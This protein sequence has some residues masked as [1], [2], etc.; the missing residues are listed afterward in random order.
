VQGYA[1]N[2]WP[3]VVDVDTSRGA[4]A[5]IE[6]RGRDTGPPIGIPLTGA[7]RRTQVVYLPYD[8]PFSSASVAKF[9]VRSTSVG[10]DGRR[11][12]APLGMFG[13]GAGPRAVGSMTIEVTDFDPA[14]ASRPDQ[15]RYAV[16][17]H[18]LFDRSAIEILRMPTT[19]D[20]LELIKDARQFP[21]PP[22]LHA[23]DWRTMGVKPSPAAGDYLLQVR[24]WLVGAAGDERDWTG[25]Y[26]PNRVRIQ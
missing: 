17:A 22:G 24:A 18:R 1:V 23:G 15:V 20:R 9:I 21:F 11:A 4:T 8:G 19:G 16:M 3:I 5:W 13:I 7:G 2:G 12:Y 6:V 26:A 25:A 14:Q 10:P